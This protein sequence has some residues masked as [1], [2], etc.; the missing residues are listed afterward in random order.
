VDELWIVRHG[1]TEWSRSGQHTGN[2][3]LPLTKQGEAQ[4]VALGARLREQRFAIVLVSPLRR[5]RR[6]AELA[7]VGE[8]AV[9]DADLVE[10]DYGDY[11]GLTT[12]QIDELQPGWEIWRDGCPHGESLPAVVARADRALERAQA[13][14]GPALVVCHSHFARVLGARG[15][16]LDGFFG[17]H[18][19]L[20][21]ASLSILGAEHGRPAIRLWN[22]ASHLADVD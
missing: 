22:D 3:D 11:E 20:D 1:E 7:G 19:T 9:L 18:L 14:E 13:A 10:W 17:R 2:T 12:A 8:A 5:A 4:A 16:G 21:T 6:T 15:L